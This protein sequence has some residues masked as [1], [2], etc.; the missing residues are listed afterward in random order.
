MD[1]KVAYCFTKEVN[2][3]PSFFE[4]SV[5]EKLK[6]Q[7]QQNIFLISLQWSLFALCGGGSLRTQGYLATTQLQLT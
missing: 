1:A 3:D 6:V 7:E 2:F 4:N 5:S